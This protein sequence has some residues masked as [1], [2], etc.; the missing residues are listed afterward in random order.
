MCDATFKKVSDQ[1]AAI[2]LAVGRSAE[3]VRSL[4]RGLGGTFEGLVV[5]EAD[6][7][8]VE[9]ENR[10]KEKPV[11]DCEQVDWS[12]GRGARRQLVRAIDREVLRVTVH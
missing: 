2:G 5:S 7:L 8:A 9:S 12:V 3:S 6:R 11:A 10:R 4:R 1:N